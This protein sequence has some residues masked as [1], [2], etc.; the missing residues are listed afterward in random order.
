[1]AQTGTPRGVATGR[2]QAIGL[3]LIRIAVG[4]Y[5]LSLG[6]MKLRWLLDSSILASQLHDWS[7]GATRISRW[8]LERVTPGVPVFARLVPL[9]ESALGAALM[10]GVWTRMVA[11][12]AFLMILN[13]QVASGVLFHLSYTH[14][15]TGLPLLA[16][17]LALVIGG[18]RLPLSLKP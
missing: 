17:L 18:A 1:M 2:G 12:A 7:G 4:I 9:G 13:Y 8:Y 11:G 6:V 3:A 16:S 14:D 10:A 5:L 15:P